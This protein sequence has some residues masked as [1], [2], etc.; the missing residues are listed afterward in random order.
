MLFV[1]KH[2]NTNLN[3]RHTVFGRSNFLLESQYTK[4][5]NDYFLCIGMTTSRDSKALRCALTGKIRHDT[6]KKQTLKLT[7]K[8]GKHYYVLRNSCNC[9]TISDCSDRPRWTL[10]S[11]QQHT[12]S[13]KVI[14]PV[15]DT[16]TTTYFL[17][18]VIWVTSDFV[19]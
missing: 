6:S 17:P 18:T 3:P 12:L 15:S 8:E 5:T 1:H 11:K 4:F 7:Q 2:M 16:G 10:K 9:G 13:S 19:S 14:S